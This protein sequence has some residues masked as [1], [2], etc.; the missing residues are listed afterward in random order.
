MTLSDTFP[1]EF[2]EQFELHL[3]KHI[4]ERK[5]SH[6]SHPAQKST[7]TLSKTLVY[8]REDTQTLMKRRVGNILELI[9][10]GKEVLN[11]TLAVQPP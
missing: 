3:K 4:K 11:R 10:T 9:F 6:I 7:P 1:F 2:V 8:I 5:Q